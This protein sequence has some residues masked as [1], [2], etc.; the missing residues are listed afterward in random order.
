[1]S[2]KS[3]VLG[4]SEGKTGGCYRGG[5]VLGNWGERD[6]DGDQASKRMR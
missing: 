2:E 3:S 1:M 6:R 4:G 5:C